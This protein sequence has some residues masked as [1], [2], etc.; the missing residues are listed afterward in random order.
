MTKGT[1]SKGKK[2]PSIHSR[3]A[4]RATSPGIDTDKSLKNVKPPED[5]RPNT[6]AAHHSAGI[7]K[8]KRKVVMSHKARK[9]HEKSMDRAEAVMGRTENKV[10]KSVDHFKVIKSRNRAW[11]EIN[12]EV[13]GVE[14]LPKK[15]ASKDPSGD[16][17]VA[18]FYADDDE[19]MDEMKLD[20]VNE[21]AAPAPIPVN[22]VVINGDDEE[23]L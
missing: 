7:T 19:E 14:I 20:E 10:K 6:L 5:S 23:I 17:A 18:A 2:G 4:R 15:K 11:D 22:T 13:S 8:K 3:A 9:R 1:I 12:R 21:V 16:A